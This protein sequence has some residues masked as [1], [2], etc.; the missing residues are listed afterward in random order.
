MLFLQGTRDTLATVDQIEPLRESLGERATL[1]LFE[2]ADHSFRM[3]ARTGR[4]DAQ[5]WSDVLD[6]LVAWTDV[7]GQ[8]L[9]M[10]R[11]ITA[12]W[13]SPRNRESSERCRFP[14]SAIAWC[15]ER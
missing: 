5:V 15:R 9:H 10:L 8:H 4:K 1:K 6:A 12:G 14:A 2:G 11:S 7:V 3:P 13:T